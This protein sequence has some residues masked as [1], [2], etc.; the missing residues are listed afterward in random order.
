MIEEREKTSTFNNVYTNTTDINDILRP[1]VGHLVSLSGQ[2]TAVFDSVVW[3]NIIKLA[4]RSNVG[5]SKYGTT[6][7]ESDDNMIKH[8]LEELLDASNY[9]Q[10]YLKDK[11]N[12]SDKNRSNKTKKR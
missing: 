4:S 2:Y 5:I 11:D 1:P 9:V 6:L 12:N 8:L 10:A 7:G 3:E